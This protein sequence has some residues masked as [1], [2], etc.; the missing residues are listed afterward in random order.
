[1]RIEIINTGSELLLG[2]VLNTHQ[3]WLCRQLSDMGWSVDRQVAVPDTATAIEHAVAESLLRAELVLV[4]GGLGPTSDDLTRDRIA[5]LLGLKLHHDE[6]IAGRIAAYFAAR[7]R[8]QPPSTD[9]QAFVP[10]GAIVLQNDFGTAP[11]LALE[12]SP[13][14]KK[15]IQDKISIDIPSNLR[16]PE[17][18][19]AVNSSNMNLTTRSWLVMLPGP[20]REL[21][22][23]FL[24]HV[25]PLLRRVLPPPEDFACRI[26]R[27][28]GVGE[29]K[30]EELLAPHLTQLVK[31]GLE[32][33]YC[34]RPGEVDLRFI[35]RGSQ[36][37]LLV[38][39]A[40]EIARSLFEKHIYG[41]GEDELEAVIVKR[42]TALG[43]KLAVAESCTGGWLANRIT[44]VPGASAV[45]WGGFL[46]YDNQ[47]KIKLL[48]VPEPILAA[49]GAVSEPV[50]KAMCEGTRLISGADYALAVTGIAGPSGGTPTKPVG[51]VFIGL[52]SPKGV[53]VKRFLNPFDRETFKSVT[54]QQ[55]LDM[56]RQ[57]LG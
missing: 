9:V 28:T 33:G 39:K 41:E 46:T 22:P 11:G 27:L 2:R 53:D 43:L 17:D 42:M 36:S 45:F 52:A 57:A 8:P 54:S 24:N 25:L 29:S 31:N 47:A 21:R 4:T 49:H 55:A 5:S 30:L 56:L 50:A 16:A 14:Q 20:P 18:A 32:L 44:N 40:A 26:L 7:N 3:Q 38:N 15:K 23:M 19:C 6:S 37:V 34:S 13:E 51:T 12:V 1:M 35:A 10:E 48:K